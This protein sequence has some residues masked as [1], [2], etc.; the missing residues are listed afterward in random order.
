MTSFRSQRL[1]GTGLYYYNAR[2]YD[3]GMGRFISPDTIIPNPANPQSF[4]RYSYCLNNPLKYTDPSGRKV[5]LGGI[6]YNYFTTAFNSG[7]YMWFIQPKV[8]S[9]ISSPEFRAYGLVRQALPGVT[10]TLESAKEIVNIQFGAVSEGH[11]AETKVFDI[12]IGTADINESSAY[13][14]MLIGHEAVHVIANLTS[15][16][17]RN[18]IFEE[19]VAFHVGNYVA[20]ITGSDSRWNIPLPS[21]IELQSGYK[22][23]WLG[24]ELVGTKI[25]WREIPSLKK[26]HSKLE[27]WPSQRVFDAL[28]TQIIENIWLPYFDLIYSNLG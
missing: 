2:Y 9:T 13:I 22:S 4:N 3:A 14:A 10:D 17:S 23:Q 20:D 18:S 27:L 21:T 26:D 25:A 28:Q 24:T 12:T 11:A 15:P 16:S 19:S 7:N 1:D 8:L 5:Y 6:D